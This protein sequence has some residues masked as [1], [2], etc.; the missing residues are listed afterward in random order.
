MI[1]GETTGPGGIVGRDAELQG[2]E[3]GLAADAAGAGREEVAVETGELGLGH[4]R[5]QLDF[6]DVGAAGVRTLAGGGAAHLPAV[7]DHAFGEEEAQGQLGVGARGAHGDGHGA[8]AVPLDQADL[9]RLLGGHV[10]RPLLGPSGTDPEDAGVRLA[11]LCDAEAAH[12][13]SFSQI[14]CPS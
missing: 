9:Q 13:V 1:S 11:G 6:E 2:V 10:V 12:G 7:S 14:E 4:A 3:P 5:R 8:R